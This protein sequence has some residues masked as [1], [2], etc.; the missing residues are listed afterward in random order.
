[1]VR[2]ILRFSIFPLLLYVV[3]LAWFMNS[4]PG[5]AGA[6]RTDGIV[7]LTGGPGRVS[8]GF[9]LIQRGAAD[10]LLI[11]GVA[12]VVRPQELAAEHE[13]AMDLIRCCV[14]LGRDAT[15]TR[16]NGEEVAEWVQRHNMKSIRVVTND[17]H[18][19]RA[20]KEISWRLGRGTKVVADGVH[21]PRTFP[22][23]FLE[24]NKYLISP[25]GEQLGLE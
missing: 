21:S 16:T 14:D 10:R 3:G 9:E 15:D 11:S 2:N 4:L 17:W 12:D 8:R 5:P 20:R 13:V 7:V 23:I 18:M 22:Q 6:E 1:M 19:P 25:F 24:Y